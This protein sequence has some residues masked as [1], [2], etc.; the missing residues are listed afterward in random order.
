MTGIKTFLVRQKLLRLFGKNK[1]GEE[2][3]RIGMRRV[4]GD[5]HRRYD[6]RDAFF[7]VD[8]LE[9]ITLFQRLVIEILGAVYPHRPLSRC[10]HAGGIVG[11]LD[12]M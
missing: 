3:G 11:R 1:L 12:D 4:F 9:R 7:G 8:D 2:F 6:Q 10:H 5:G